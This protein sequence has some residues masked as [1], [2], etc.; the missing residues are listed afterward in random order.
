MVK[1]ISPDSKKHRF[2]A[3]IGR[4]K[5]VA[6]LRR[7]DYENRNALL[8]RLRETALQN[9]DTG[10]IIIASDMSK[11][12]GNTQVVSVFAR[13]DKVMYANKFTL[14]SARV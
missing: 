7:Q 5:F 1:S 13:A 2:I 8:S 11:L 4:D 9:Q 12:D 10:D 6:V 14:K 3:R